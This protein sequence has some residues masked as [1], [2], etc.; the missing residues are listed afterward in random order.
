MYSVDDIR[1]PRDRVDADLLRR[2]LDR[3]NT[4]ECAAASAGCCDQRSMTKGRAMP[5]G[6]MNA[7]CELLKSM[8]LAMAYAPCQYWREIYG[9]E[10]A[11][12][13]GTMFKEL[14]K[15]WMV[16]GKRGGCG[17]GK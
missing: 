9:P 10:M 12:R 6:E 2:L 11:L 13:R 16:E 14:D 17:C 7:S 8:P 4:L 15:P 1:T 3:E 5:S